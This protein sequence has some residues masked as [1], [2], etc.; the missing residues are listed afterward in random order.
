MKSVNIA[1]LKNN[2]SAYVRKARAGEEILI[3]DRNVPVAKMVPLPVPPIDAEEAAL[4]AAGK[5]TLPKKPF[6]EKAFWA[7]GA[8]WKR[9]PRLVRAIQEA[10]SRERDERDD[11][12]LGL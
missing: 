2:L 12:V 6:D 9:N 10:I 5:I 7:I 8:K 11:S 4:A 1:E 3:K